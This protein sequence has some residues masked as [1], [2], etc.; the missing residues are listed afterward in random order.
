M[1][2][3]GLGPVGVVAGL[4]L[5]TQT[6]IA[7]FFAS[8]NKHLSVR[9]KRLSRLEPAH[10]DL[11]DWAYQVRRRAA[12]RGWELPKLPPSVQEYYLEEEQEE[13]L[14][15]EMLGQQVVQRYEASFIRE[16]PP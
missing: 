15:L 12:A 9:S 8:R 10:L 6:G 1:E 5:L 4:I 16:P 14:E 13:S 7:A 3:L 2:T 11:L